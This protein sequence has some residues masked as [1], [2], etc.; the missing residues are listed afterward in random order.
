[1]ANFP[2]TTTN[3]QLHADSKDDRWKRRS[4]ATGNL[5]FCSS[6]GICNGSHGA[7]SGKLAQLS[8]AVG[9][10]L[11]VEFAAGSIFPELDHPRPPSPT[12]AL[13]SPSNVGSGP[14]AMAKIVIG[15]LPGFVSGA[16]RLRY[17]GEIKFDFIYIAPAPAFARF[18]RSHD[19][20][21]GSV[22]V[23]GCVFILRRVA[24]A[25]MAAR[26]A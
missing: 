16:R 5:F 7:M 15:C 9:A 6:V 24:A 18:Q 25:D 26:H 1:M 8:F 4:K 20:M 12:D 21:L 11:N 22:E 23:L 10:S 2:E 14:C 19:W 13:L 3:L 17:P